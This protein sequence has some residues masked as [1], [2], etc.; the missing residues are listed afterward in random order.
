A[1]REDCPIVVSDEV[2]DEAGRPPEAFEPDDDPA[3]FDPTDSDLDDPGGPDD[4][5]DFDF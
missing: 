3:A 4:P 5:D 1:L 2:I